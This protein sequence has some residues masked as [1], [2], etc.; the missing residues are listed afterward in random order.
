MLFHNEK[1]NENVEQTY[2]FIISLPTVRTELLFVVLT[3]AT[4]NY[5][6]Y[7]YESR[8]LQFY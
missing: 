2:K 6:I 8:L 7:A 1:Q 4:P 5:M 3:S